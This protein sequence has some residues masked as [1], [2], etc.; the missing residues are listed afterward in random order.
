MII[1][2]WKHAPFKLPEFPTASRLMQAN[3]RLLDFHGL[4][5]G[6]ISMFFTKK[7]HSPLEK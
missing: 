1:P 7:I 2:G 3:F 4:L 6:C 5:G